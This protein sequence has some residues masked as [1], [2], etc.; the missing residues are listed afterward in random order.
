[1]FCWLS[2]CCCTTGLACRCRL[3]ASGRPPD[4]RGQGGRASVNQEP[5]R[6]WGNFD[7]GIDW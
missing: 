4:H 3:R 2:A 5:Q 7:F 1:M 6:L